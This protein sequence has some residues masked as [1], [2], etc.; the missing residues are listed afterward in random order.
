MDLWKW[1]WG[2][3]TQSI[4]LRKGTGGGDLWIR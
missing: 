1:V 4:C 3:W 2:T